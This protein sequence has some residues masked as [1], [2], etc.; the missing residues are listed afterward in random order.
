M[1]YL[2]TILIAMALLIGTDSA[3]VETRPNIVVILADDLGY[4]D[5]GCQGCKD[6]P[7]PHIDSIAKNGI[8]FT[9][10]YA[11][12]PVCSPSRAGLLSGRYQHRFGFEH[13]SG[14]ESYAAVNFGLP[15]SEPTLAE[16]LKAAGYA[17]GMVGK[18]HIGFREG[19]RPWERG[20]D[21]FYGFLSGGR[22]Y[23]P[24]ND[25]KIP[26]IRNGESVMDE[27]EYL[28]DAFA[29]EAVGFIERSKGKPFFLYLAFNAVHA[30]LE[31]TAKYE[32]RFPNIGNSDRRTYAGM[33]AAMDDAVGRVLAR[34][35]KHGLEKNTLV[36][37]YSDNGGPTSLTTSRN[38]PLK[39]FKNTVWEGGVR[40][41]FM[42]QWPGSLPSGKTYEK[43][44]MGFDVHAP[45]L[46]A[47]GLPLPTDKP[48]DGV[49]LIPFLTGKDKGIP[50]D[51]L[52]WR[53]GNRKYA[54]RVGDWKLVM[55][56][57]GEPQLYNLKKDIGETSNLA[58]SKP[59]MLKA[60]LDAYEE[61]DGQMAPAK[62]IRQDRKNAEVGGKLKA[63]STK[64]RKSRQQGQK[65]VE[66]RFRE[67]DR[68]GGEK[69]T[70]DEIKNPERFKGMD[71]DGDGA[72]T[73]EEV[74]VYYREKA[75][76]S[77]SSQPEN[78]Q[79]Q[80][81]PGMRKS[82]LS[83]RKSEAPPPEPHTEEIADQRPGE[84]PLK[85]MPDGDAAS[86]AAGRGQLFESISAPGFTDFQQGMNGFALADLNRDGL[87]DLVAVCSPARRSR[88]SGLRDNLHVWLNQGGF[89]FKPYTLTL[90]SSDVELDNFSQG[91]VPNLADF[92]GDGYL[93][94]FISRTA[95][96]LGGQRR[97]KAK[98]LGN[99]FF[100]S[101]GSWDKFKDVSKKMGI[102][103][104][105]AYNRQ[106][107]F[108]DVNRDGWLDIAVG[109]DNI[110]NAQGGFPHSRLYVY[111]PKETT[112]KDIGGTK[113]VPDFGGFYNDPDKDKAGPDI[114]LVDLDNDGDL[115]LLQTYHVDVGELEARY[116]PIEYR[117]GVFCWKNLLSETG[118][119]KYEK[120]TGN[121]LACEARLRY[122][123][124][125]KKLK[126]EGKAPGLPYVSFADTDNDG[127]LDI[128]AV[129][130]IARPPGLAFPRTEYAGGRFW[131]NLGNFR[132][133]VATDDVGLTPLT[134]NYG[135][136]MEF[137]D[138]PLPR[139]PKAPLQPKDR[140]PYYSDALFG[141]YN[142]DGWQDI[143]VM[144]RN[145]SS[146][147]ATRAALFMNRGD[148]TFEVKPTTFSGL[149]DGGIS[150]EAADLN[151]DG[152]LDLVF[153]QDP[154]NTGVA[155]GMAGYESRIYWN[156]GLHGAKENHWLRLR[157]SGVSDAELIGARIEVS[158][159]GQKQYRWI[160]SNHAYKSGSPLEAHFGLGKNTAAD[161]TVQLPN[162]NATVYKN[163]KVD[164]F[165]DLDL[166]GGSTVKVST[167]D[168][169]DYR[170]PHMEATPK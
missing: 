131:R 104:E 167:N 62:W 100:L 152:L 31:A 87:L 36:F 116:S 9:D 99:S 37:F 92:N 65:T 12:H 161:V 20:F 169:A 134:W 136:W 34:L 5:L 142:N 58:D 22:T 89:R 123:T 122:S 148:G 44:V 160:Q 52:F 15:R 170:Y 59:E 107:A 102:Q 24:G 121:G 54:A 69:L 164:R 11:N 154:D 118:K 117:Q 3:A 1:K 130:P 143:V 165:L 158:A 33:T 163:L 101:D 137:F 96:M 113:L 86:D 94:I 8:R 157:F 73:I 85:K 98:M 80:S 91:Q 48:L 120:V 162:G 106:P 41:P 126:A 156:T 40:V 166:K 26:L 70:A 63:G 46:A 119:L 76:E 14:P 29:R 2:Y 145:E 110:K 139:R 16:R 56:K 108:G 13:N 21:Y 4:A 6:I 133:E 72:A 109:C 61:W 42:V 7:T 151:N 129:G 127:D 95:P 140:F 141:D 93:D 125:T 64:G 30:P 84:P 53:S 60:M 19:L 38:D 25:D 32:K 112:F 147:I 103:N 51:R 43:M 138:A 78:K 74:R 124:K 159:N 111:Q 27:K 39:G 150:G 97:G 45:A 23:M 155:L 114:N 49:N 81:D 135:R 79:S 68:N 35:R 153:A 105:L 55:E 75:K 82:L 10:G 17:T 50:H 57:G 71:R 115:D 128:L 88:A 77:S 28:T 149:D 168:S 146:F 67:A 47:A 18:W 90:R 144:D 132:F 66:A 83:I